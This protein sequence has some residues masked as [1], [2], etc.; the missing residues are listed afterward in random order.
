MNVPSEGPVQKRSMLRRLTG[1]GVSAGVIAAIVLGTGAGVGWLHQRAAAGPEEAA[2][3]A[4]PVTVTVFSRQQSYTERAS[5]LGRVEARRSVALGAEEQAR[6]IS[7]T[8]EEGETVRAGTILA[9][10]DASLILA[11]RAAAVAER[12]RAAADLSLA[13]LEEKRQERLWKQGHV[14]EAV[15]DAARF[16]REALQAQVVALEAQIAALDIRIARHEI[17]APFDGVV[18]ARLMDEGAI[19]SPGA[20]VIRLRERGAPEARIGVPSAISARFPLDMPQMLQ[21]AGRT[22]EGVLTASIPDIDPAT[23]SVALIFRLPPQMDAPEGET[24]ELAAEISH[25]GTGGWLPVTALREGQKG[26]WTV[27]VVEDGVVVA[28]AVRVIALSGDRAFV[29]GT[30]AEGARVVTAGLN[31][32]APGQAVTASEE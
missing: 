2:P 26:L 17:R 25:D 16:Q 6:L 9:R 24:V 19:A 11:E 29:D 30:L 27:M 13:Q 4:L 12:N 20:P 1:L 15:Y 5:Y 3:Q 8:V 31:R 22:V 14:S 28:E 10:L 32:I 7:V 18:T 21:I 23:R